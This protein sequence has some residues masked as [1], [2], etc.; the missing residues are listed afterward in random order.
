ME[1]L[2]TT[3]ASMFK[4]DERFILHRFY[5]T[6]VSAIVGIVAIVTWF[7]YELLVNDLYRWDLAAIAGMMAASK[8]L[9]MPYLR[10]TR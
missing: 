4:P 7:N 3:I 10:L 6:R 8:L 1:V 2:I 5:S 9:V